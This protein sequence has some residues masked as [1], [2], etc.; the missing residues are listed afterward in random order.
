MRLALQTEAELAV[1]RSRR[2]VGIAD[3]LLIEIAPIARQITVAA[4]AR[5]TRE[6]PITGLQFTITSMA[7]RRGPRIGNDT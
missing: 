5:Q 4:A 7:R 1:A 3:T 2:P 6:C